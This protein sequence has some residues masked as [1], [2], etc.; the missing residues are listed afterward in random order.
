MRF[1]M[2]K[3]TKKDLL[4]KLIEASDLKM[5]DNLA[6]RIV[7]TITQAGKSLRNVTIPDL[8]ELIIEIRDEISMTKLSVPAEAATKK[9]GAPKKSSKKVEVE[10]EEPEEEED[11]DDDTDEDEDEV[12]EPPK[13]EKPKKALKNKSMKTAKPK[14]KASKSLPVAKMFPSEITFDAEDGEVNLVCVHDKYHTVNDVRK[15][16]EDG[17]TLYIAAYWTKRHIKEYNYAR[18]FELPSSPKQFP[19][20][21]DILNIVIACDSLE[22]VFAM[23]TYTEAL[24]M[25]DADSFRPV[26]DI[27]ENGEEFTVRV[28][29]GMEF[30]V[31]VAEE[32]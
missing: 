32:E 17:V 25:F 31:Y 27:D 11:V 30:E 5:S 24:Y 10:E 14:T 18:Q 23:S 21:L 3:M 4:G 28:T 29:N 19:D 26:E 22:R 12:E 20:D 15:A 16:L 8:K 9:S 7:Y 1:D 2:N 6:Q 13:K